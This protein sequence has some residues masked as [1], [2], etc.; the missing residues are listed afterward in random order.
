M[1]STPSPRWK[2]IAES[3]A[4][5]IDRGELEPGSRLAG[6][7]QIAEEWGVSRPTAHRAVADLQRQGYVV[8]QRRWGTVVADRNRRQSHLVA[9]IFDRF[10]KDFDFPQ[11]ELIAGI[12]ES[13][14]E[15]YSLVWCDS[16][17]DPAREAEHLRKMAETA[18]GIICHPIANPANTRLM[19]KLVD[20]GFPIV[21]LDRVPHGYHGHAVVSDDTAATA[22]A[23][24]R[25]I[26]QGKRRIAFFSFHKPDVS[27]A[28]QRYT[29]YADAMDRAGCRD[30]ARLVRWFARE[31]DQRDD[32]LGRAVADAVYTL[33]HQAPS[34]DA[35][36]CVQDMFA[37]HVLE[38]LEAL[39]DSVSLWPEI[40][41]INE[42]PPLSLKRPWDLHRIVRRK[43]EIGTCATEALLQQI[44]R[45]GTER[46]LVRVPADLF[47]AEEG[48]TF[49]AIDVRAWLPLNAVTNGGNSH[50]NPKQ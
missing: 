38:A 28:W 25:L 22:T 21:L 18:D 45:R 14:G 41:T 35:I 36:Y 24:E 5:R 1:P 32:F 39:G 26:D 19:Q 42:W 13:L 9:L 16:K 11:S 29:S 10:A 6:E 30:D 37:L 12:Q 40:V 49:D 15:H 31:F 50:E 47:P 7:A 46:G 8:R 48:P 44:E 20:R 3:L 2:Q 33:V 43:R 34:V 17:D 4:A 23:I 27:S